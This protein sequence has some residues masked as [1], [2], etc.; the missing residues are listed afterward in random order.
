VAPIDPADIADIV[1]GGD[2]LQVKARLI[3]EGALTGLHRARL[4][5]S[6]VEFAEHKEYTPGDEVRHIDWKAYAKLDRYFVKQFEQESQLTAFL[7]LDASASMG[8]RSDRF[9]KLEYGA[10]LISALA[11]LLIRQQDKVG[12]SVFG[13]STLEG[14][15]PPRARPAHLHDLLA[16]IQ[17]VS[18]RGAAG[19]EPVAAA[20][21]RIGELASRKRSVILLASDLFDSGGTAT[22]I[23]R[24]LRA[25]RHDVIVF[26][27][28]DPHEIDFPFEGL[29]LFEAL[30]SERKMLV[31]PGA[32]RKR[33]RQQFDEF[34]TRTRTDCMDGGIDYH[35]APTSKPLERT[36]L[37]FLAQRLSSGARRRESTWSS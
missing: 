26:H 5:G 17:D 2:S 19:D 15:V 36:V 20:L 13:D 3:V 31:N 23:L 34:L 33:Y 11:Y 27:I 28:L 22:T 21:D 32:I 9:S 6:S 7:L 18:E 4:H 8:Y 14:Y 24:R 1:A 10:Y 16:A 12:L 29:T 37:D 30:E 25:Q 35:L